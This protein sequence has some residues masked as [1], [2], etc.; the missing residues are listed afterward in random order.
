MP[1]MPVDWCTFFSSVT[2]DS[3]ATTHPVL[4]ASGNKPHPCIFM[5]S[6]SKIFLLNPLL[7]L[8]FSYCDIFLKQSMY[9]IYSKGINDFAGHYHSYYQSAQAASHF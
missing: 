6:L 7:Q 5:A 8:L 2:E 3:M 9:Y 4:Q 1:H